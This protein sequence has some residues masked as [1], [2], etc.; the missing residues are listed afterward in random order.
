V[1]EF[2]LP[3]PRSSDSVG[4]ARSAIRE[5]LV[6]LPG[7]VAE[8]SALLANELVANAIAHGEGSISLSM[9]IRR[10][11][12]RVAVTDEGTVLPVL[13]ESKPTAE[14]GRGLSIVDALATRWGAHPAGRGKSVWFELAIHN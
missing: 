5:A 4:R 3:L 2:V 10:D 13:R 14:S 9:E 12:V 8:V 1:A 6:G 11:C 7:D